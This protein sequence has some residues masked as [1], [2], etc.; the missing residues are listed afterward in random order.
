MSL[1]FGR[2]SEANSRLETPSNVFK[3]SIFGDDSMILEGLVVF[4]PE[5][6]RRRMALGGSTWPGGGGLNLWSSGDGKTMRTFCGL[7][8]PF[9]AI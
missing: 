8:L 1:G 4:Q 5:R 3:P 6:L 9:G 7:K 2:V